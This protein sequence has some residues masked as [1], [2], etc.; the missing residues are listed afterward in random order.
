MSI[1]F[2]DLEY[3][4]TVAHARTLSAASEKLGLAQPSLSLA[5]KKLES[6]LKVSLFFRGRNGIQLTPQGRNLLPEAEAALHL[7]EKIMGGG[8]ELR[9]SIGC[10]PSVGMFV[11]SSFLQAIHRAGHK[12]KLKIVNGS[13]VEINKRVALGE[14]D[15]GIVMNPLNIPGLIT[16][17]MGRDEVA[18]W[19]S[20]HRYRDSLIYHPDLLQSTSILS[21]WPEAPTDR[22]EVSNL[23]LIASLVDSGAGMGILPTQVVRAQRFALEHVPDTPTHQDQLALICYPAVLQSPEGKIIYQELKASFNSNSG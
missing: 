7:L 5:I 10:H 9:F 2:K 20:P 11:L 12:V 19:Q 3:F 15:F 1:K 17:L 21:N 13:S 22:I 4:V 18:V 8:P 23:E 14:I 6:E 16:K